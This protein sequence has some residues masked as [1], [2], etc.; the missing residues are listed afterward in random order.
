MDV[1]VENPTEESAQSISEPGA[2]TEH[3]CIEDHEENEG[4]DIHSESDGGYADEVDYDAVIAD[5]MRALKAEFPELASMT[6]ITELDNPVRYAALRD[7][8]LTPKE[9]YLATSKRPAA[10]TRSHLKA[11]YGRHTSAPKN[12]M[13]REE[14]AVAKDV[15]EGLSD[16]EIISLYKRVSGK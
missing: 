6:D 15:F 3:P 11:T 10:D 5:D 7:L 13:S 8:G 12:T 4:G 2:D 9:A 14:L 16:A 1:T